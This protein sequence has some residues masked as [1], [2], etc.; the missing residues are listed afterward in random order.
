[1]KKY[2]SLFV[3]FMSE[4]QFYIQEEQKAWVTK[5]GDIDPAYYHLLMYKE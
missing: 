2:L 1:M 3:F 4:R 5:H